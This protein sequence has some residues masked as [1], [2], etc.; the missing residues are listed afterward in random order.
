MDD[1]PASAAPAIRPGER[2]PLLLGRAWLPALDGPSVV[3]VRD[4]EVIDITS[5]QAP[6][7][8][9]VCEMPDPAAYVAAAPGQP[10]GS[11]E[12]LLA[13]STVATW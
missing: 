1:I 5:P 6:T 12:K 8:R 7:V 11:L 3:T 9:D 4:G 13:D 2:P 10:V